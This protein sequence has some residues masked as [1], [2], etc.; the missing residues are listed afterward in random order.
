MTVVTLGP[1]KFSITED[2]FRSSFR[3]FIISLIVSLFLAFI[4]AYFLSRKISSIPI[5]LS[6]QLSLL[7]QGK[8]D[9]VFSSS[10]IKELNLISETATLLQTELLHNQQDRTEFMR[11][12]GHD[13]KT[14]LTAM[15][16]IVEGLVDG[17]FPPDD[18]IFEKLQKQLKEL[19]QKSEDFLFISKLDALEVSPPQEYFNI[20]DAINSLIEKYK[21]SITKR[22]LKIITKIP[23]NMEKPIV[24]ADQKLLR[25]AFEHIFRNMVDYAEPASTAIV[26]MYIEDKQVCIIF[27]NKGNIETQSPDQLLKYLTKG[28]WSRST[29]GSGLG[30]TI[31]KKIISRHSGRITI[32]SNSSNIITV[33]VTLPLA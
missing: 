32:N 13:L 18:I 22:D 12:L 27:E 4:L 8:R 21:E 23:E 29:S 11:N 6:K 17:V 25:L 1:T 31:A 2:F 24:M 20:A 30:L 10:S 16:V 3:V 7:T 9:I 14:P 33:T 5:K 19:E 28:N 26:S 15:N